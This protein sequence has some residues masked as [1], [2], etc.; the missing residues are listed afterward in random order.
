[1]YSYTANCLHWDFVCTTYTQCLR[2]LQK[3]NLTHLHTRKQTLL[4]VCLALEVMEKIDSDGNHQISANELAALMGRSDYE[5]LLRVCQKSCR[6]CENC[7]RTAA[8]GACKVSQAR[9]P[10]A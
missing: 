9:V 10:L 2:G 3:H 7:R 5:G 4:P 1:M 8:T 6:R